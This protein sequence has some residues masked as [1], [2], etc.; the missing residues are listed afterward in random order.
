MILSRHLSHYA[1]SAG[2]G[3]NTIT[4]RHGLCSV[5]S[6]E[7]EGREQTIMHYADWG[8]KTMS[9]RSFARKILGK[10]FLNENEA[11]VSSL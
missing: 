9:D 2:A 8:C 3:Y 1:V 7:E 4:P 6:S 11:S 5:F 10:G